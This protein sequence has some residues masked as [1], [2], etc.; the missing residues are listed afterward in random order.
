M[1]EITQENTA[2]A[3]GGFH[4]QHAVDPPES[5][6]KP[7]RSEV[8]RVRAD[9]CEQARQRQVVGN[10]LI[11]G[12]DGTSLR[13]QWRPLPWPLRPP[14]G[15]FYGTQ[16]TVVPRESSLDGSERGGSILPRATKNHAR[17]SCPGSSQSFPSVRSTSSNEIRREC[18]FHLCAHGRH[19]A[20]GRPRSS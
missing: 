4:E 11:S 16:S 5:G 6:F 2:G 17:H 7:G 3:I 9:S 8:S 13:I 10:S 19:E 18:S 15:G 12:R 1:N 14:R 20:H